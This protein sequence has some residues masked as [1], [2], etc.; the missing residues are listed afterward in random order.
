M[1]PVLSIEI[2]IVLFTSSGGGGG[3]PG[4]GGCGTA[5]SRPFGVNGVMVMKITSKTSRIS[6]N[7][8]TLI[9]ALADIFL[10][11][12][13]MLAPPTCAPGRRSVQSTTR[14]DPHPHFEYCR[15]LGRRLRT[16]PD[17]RF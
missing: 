1:V 6:I 7:G 12:F 15:Q 10:F 17:C 8:V 14:P 4:G 13:F 11:A 3:V 5:A 16:W 2:T 9:S